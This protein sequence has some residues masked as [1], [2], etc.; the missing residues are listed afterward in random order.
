M[1]FPGILPKSIGWTEF[2]PPSPHTA[3]AV[4]EAARAGQDG[5]TSLP[6]Q[7]SGGAI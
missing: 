1:D 3:S 2:E 4:A 6:V 7:S 5:A